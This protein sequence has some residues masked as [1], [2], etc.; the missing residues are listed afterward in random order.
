MPALDF[1]LGHRMIGRT[2]KVFDLAVVEP[3][4]EVTGDVGV[5]G[6]FVQNRTLRRKGA[7]LAELA[8]SA[9]M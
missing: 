1:A 4:G 9:T 2:A 7:T 5:T 3:F 6:R 8:R